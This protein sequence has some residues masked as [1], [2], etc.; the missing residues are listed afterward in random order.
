[1]VI[2]NL[3]EHVDGLLGKKED[4]KLKNLLMRHGHGDVA[5]VLD[6]LSH[7]KRKAFVL[8]PPEIQAEVAL[9]VTE[10]TRAFIL[11]RLSD[12]ALARFLHF[13]NEDDAAD[14]L[15]ELPE[16]RRSLILR[17][18]K[19]DKR[20][21]IEKLLK[22]SPDTAGGLMDLNFITVIEESTIKEVSDKVRQHAQVHKQAPIVIVV[23]SHEHLLGFVPYRTLMFNPPTKPVAD[24]LTPLV[25]TSS[26]TDQEKVLKI[27]TQKKADLIGVVDDNQFLGV[28]HLQDLLRVAQM[29]ATEDFYLFAGVNKEEE[30]SDSAFAAV[31]FRYVWLI[32]NLATAFLAAFV[33]SRFQ[34]TIAKT[35][36][37]AA[38]MPIVAG[39]GGNAG[40]QTLAVVVRG[41][42]LGEGTRRK[43]WWWHVISKEAIAGL[44]NGLINGLIVATVVFLL[45]GTANIAIILLFS[46]IINLVVAGVFGAIVPLALKALKIDPAISATVFVTTATDVV[47]FLAFLGLASAFIK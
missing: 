22:F 32:I 28:I 15:H 18:I 21:K 3:L 35:A 42:A 45:N 4:L 26:K 41:L 24:L 11:P 8:L 40:T 44:I 29:E 2:S 30:L 20:T 1:M 47:G 34:G 12:H 7:G 13:N 6:R 23:D 37:L 16:E 33:V 27:A 31:K 19:D 25:T 39:M 14:L 5:L 38:Y 17:H 36:I 9:L 46:M 43:G 10:N